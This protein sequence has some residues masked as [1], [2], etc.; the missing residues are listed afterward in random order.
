MASSRFGSNAS[1]QNLGESSRS[2]MFEGGLQSGRNMAPSLPPR[3]YDVEYGELFYG[4][5]DP[6]GESSR[7]RF[8]EGGTRSGD[9]PRPRVRPRDLEE[10]DMIGR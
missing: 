3:M 2:G 7:A 9:L 5:R 8:P 6:F 1:L 4:R 10:E